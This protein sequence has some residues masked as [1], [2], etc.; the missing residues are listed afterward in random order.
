MLK[1]LAVPFLTLA[2]ATFGCSSS[3]T[4][5]TGSGGAG[6]TSS[7]GAAGGAAG[8]A[9][10][11]AAGGA[12]GGAAGG[13]SGGAA[14]GASGGA[15]GGVAGTAGHGG[16]GGLGVGG[17]G[18]GAIDAGAS[19]IKMY[20]VTLNGPLEGLPTVTG[21]GTATVTLDTVS[22]A[23]TVTGT[24]TGLTGAA[25]SAHIH[26]P[27]LPGATAGIVVTL[28]VTPGTPA[29]GGT[30]STSP[31]A[32]LTPALVTDMLTGMTYLNIHT[33]ANTGGEIR[34][35]INPPAGS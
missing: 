6:G 20:A 30:I 3:T 22:G 10:G 14:G 12:S 5:S 13:A 34:G 26:G 25:M 31:G 35:N 8:H 24:Y 9:S 19:T 29:T 2:V 7:G 23:V 28:V 16:A 33:A 11:G 17:L 4:P 32:T 18:G 15:A 1:K 21:T 27:A